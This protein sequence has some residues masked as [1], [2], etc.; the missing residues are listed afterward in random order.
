MNKLVKFPV[1]AQYLLPT[2][3]VLHLDMNIGRAHLLLAITNIFPGQTYIYL[4]NP[5]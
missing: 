2:R 1:N 4:G 3:P 5:K